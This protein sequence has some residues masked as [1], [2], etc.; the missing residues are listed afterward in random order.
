MISVILCSRTQAEADAAE[1]VYAKALGGVQHQIIKVL[2]APSMSTGYNYGAENAKGDVLIFTHD[3]IEILS[4]DFSARLMDHLEHADLVG[5]AGTTH[6][7]GPNWNNAGLLHVYGQ[8][9]HGKRETGEM[10]V[11]IF[12]VPGP[13]VDGIEALDGVMI[14]A[15]RAV[16]DKVKFDESIPGFHLYDLDFSYC[17]FRAGFK[18]CVACDL[19]LLHWSHGAYQSPEWQVAARVFMN[20]HRASF[21]K[22]ARDI[23]VTS[24]EQALA[25]M[26]EAHGE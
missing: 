26:R 4:D 2:G 13:R 6:L 12:R 7:V 9:A 3:D 18:L 16:L 10:T 11:N 19:Y 17:A 25:R 22:L 15:K 14:A 23:K 8:A 24:R 5:I 21:P 1:K 20:K